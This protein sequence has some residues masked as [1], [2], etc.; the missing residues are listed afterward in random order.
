ML[1]DAWERIAEYLPCARDLCAL[2]QTCTLLRG[3]GQTRWL[4]ARLNH[5]GLRDAVH[6]LHDLCRTA[7]AA[8]LACP[9]TLDVALRWKPV[10]D[11]MKARMHLFRHDRSV[12]SET[13]HV[14][15]VVSTTFGSVML[16]A[17]MAMSPPEPWCHPRVLVA[18]FV[19][20][21][22]DGTHAWRFSVTRHFGTVLRWDNSDL[23]VDLTH[24][25]CDALVSLN[26][27]V[28]CFTHTRHNPL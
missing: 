10:Y 20:D 7:R 17:K 1:L 16:T 3:L 23:P 15:C 18:Y 5:E 28:E 22:P 27:L 25:E 14:S 12:L 21:E 26:R 13:A 6:E 9:P 2:R 11:G 24:S 8:F 19:F 4:R